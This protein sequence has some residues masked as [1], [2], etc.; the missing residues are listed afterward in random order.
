[1]S[2]WDPDGGTE[3]SIPSLALFAD[4]LLMGADPSEG[5]VAV[6]HEERA[7]G[8]SMVLFWRKGNDRVKTE[9]P[10]FPFI[11]LAREDLFKE[12]AG[13]LSLIHI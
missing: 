7:E 11:W 2:G 12:L 3:M 5:L 6:E 1:M 13:D 10:F 9:E 8:D 4:P